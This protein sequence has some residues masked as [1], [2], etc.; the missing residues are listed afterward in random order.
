[1]SPPCRA[2]REAQFSA[3]HHGLRTVREASIIY[4][5]LS[6]LP[7]D[8]QRLGP[9]PLLKWGATMNAAR[10][11]ITA[12][13]TNANTTPIARVILVMNQ[14]QLPSLMSKRR[15]ARGR[16][17]LSAQKL[18]RDRSQ[19]L[20]PSSSSCKPSGVTCNLKASALRASSCNTPTQ[21]C[22]FERFE[23]HQAKCKPV[24]QSQY[25][26]SS[27]AARLSHPHRRG[28][29]WDCPGAVVCLG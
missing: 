24:A 20:T 7:K 29:L 4:Q 17:G 23:D 21:R 3:R 16:V 27:R 5:T 22:R 2:T 28:T 15:A 25:R 19:K 10:P 9:G 11:E 18:E 12:R 8:E 26:G 6:M 14:R 13:L 1:L